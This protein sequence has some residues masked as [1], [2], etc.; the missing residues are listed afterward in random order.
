MNV[1]EYLARSERWPDVISEIRPILVA[2]GLTE[3][4]KWAKPCYLHD[5]RNILILQEMA[6][7]LAVMFFKG[8]LLD[9]PEGLLEEQGPNSRS[10]RRLTFR[11]PAEVRKHRPSIEGFIAAAI[12]VAQSGRSVPEGPDLVLVD[13]LRVRLE[14]DASLAAAFSALTPAAAG[15]TTCTSPTP[16]SPRPGR[17]GWSAAFPR[18][19]P[20]RACGIGEPPTAGKSPGTWKES[21]ATGV[22][23]VCRGSMLPVRIA[24]R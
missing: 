5:G 6:D 20:E 22:D 2:S 1:D 13:E 10:A 11:S 14:A 8:A 16:S 18:S 19:S 3:A 15:S 12:E 7:F 21:T 23:G 9:D 17:P 4:I 24:L